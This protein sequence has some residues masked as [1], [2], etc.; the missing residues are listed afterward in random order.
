MIGSLKTNW[1]F[2][3]RFLMRIVI[4]V[5]LMPGGVKQGNAGPATRVGDTSWKQRQRD[6]VNLR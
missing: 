4:R 5:R 6:V 2:D 1:Q 3:L